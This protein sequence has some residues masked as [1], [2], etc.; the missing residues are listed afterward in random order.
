MVSGEA[1]AWPPSRSVPGPPP[2]S[3]KKGRKRAYISMLSGSYRYNI[4]PLPKKSAVSGPDLQAIPICSGAVA[5][6]LEPEPPPS[7]CWSW[8]RSRSRKPW[9]DPSAGAGA[10]PPSR[11][12]PGRR[13]AEWYL[14][15]FPGKLEAGEGSGA[16]G[17]FHPG[18]GPEGSREAG[19]HPGRFRPGKLEAARKARKDPGAGSG[20]PEPLAVLN[21]N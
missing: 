16:A 7:C 4:K 17:A 5:G 1:G 8:S 14:K 19:S 13:R 6:K 11:S 10:G 15:H 12:A 3:W 21:D 9:P 20:K 18:N 2:G